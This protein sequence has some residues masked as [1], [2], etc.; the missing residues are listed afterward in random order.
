MK[1]F[2]FVFV[3]LLVIFQILCPFNT[4]PQSWSCGSPFTDTRD[5][6]VY[7]TVLIG[8][9]CW[10][11]QNLNYGTK[12]PSTSQQTNNSI[13]EKY[14][15]NNLDINC[16]TYGG[17]YQWGELVQYI[18]GSSNSASMNKI[19]SNVQG[20]CPDGWLI[21]ADAE[22]CTLATFLENT[23]NCNTLGST[24]STAGGDM[25]EKGY[26]HW[27]SPNTGATN[28]SMF[29]GLP[30]GA[31][32]NNG[33]FSGLT[34]Q[35]GFWAWT[36]YSST[37]GYGW[38]L[39]YNSSS[40]IRSNNNKTIG[41]SVRC[42]KDCPQP[43]APSSGK[44][45]EGSTLIQWWW[46]SSTGAA[47]YKF[48]TTNDFASATDLGTNTSYIE[49]GLTCNTNYTRYIWAYNDC[50][51]SEPTILNETTGV[52][53]QVAPVEGHHV[54]SPTEIIWKWN[55]TSGA[56]SYKWNTTNNF[57]SAVDLGL[58][59]SNTETGLTP[60]T[61]YTR[62]VW[63]TNGNCGTSS[64]TLL[65]Q[66]T[67]TNTFLCGQ[68]INDPRDGGAGQNYSTILL[69]T[70]CWIQQNMNVG[71]I[72]DETGQTND[73][74]IEKL[75]S[76]N[77]SSNCTIYGGLYTWDEMMQYST[78]PGTQGICPTGWSLPTDD[79]WCALTTY[80]DNNYHCGDPGSSVANLIK[81]KGTSHWSSPNAGA[82]NASN[83][84]ALPGGGLIYPSL[85]YD[86]IGDIADLWT[87]TQSNDNDANSRQIFYDQSYVSNSSLDKTSFLSV[88][89]MKDC[90]PPQAP[91]EGIHV[92]TDR[93]IIWNWSTV[94]DA[95][96]YRWNSTNDYNSATELLTN[97]YTEEGLLPNTTYTRY[98][99]AFKDGS[100][101]QITPLHA[102]TSP[103]FQCPSHVADQDGNIYDVVQICS[104]CWTK[105]NMNVGTYIST[106]FG[107]QTDNS[108]IEKYCLQDNSANCSEWGGYYQ[109]AE[110]LQY[111]GATNNNIWSPPSGPIKGICPQG[112]HIPSSDEWS[113][114]INNY[115]GELIAGNHL[116]E[117][118]Q[119]H[120]LSP[121]A[122]DNLSGF[123]YLGN[124]IF[125]P[126]PISVWTNLG[127]IGFAWTTNELTWQP[128]HAYSATTNFPLNTFTT[129]LDQTGKRAAIGVRC[130]MDQG[131]ICQLIVDAGTSSTICLGQTTRLG[132]DPTINGGL[133][134]Y[135]FTW[136]TIP[137][138]SWS[139]NTDLNPVVAP[140]QTTTY[141]L[142]VTDF[143]G[144][145]NTQTSAVTIT[146]LPSCPCIYPIT[147]DKNLLEPYLSTNSQGIVALTGEYDGN[148]ITYGNSS[149][150]NITLTDPNDINY[151]RIFIAKFT[152]KGYPQWVH[153]I[154]C[155]DYYF[156]YTNYKQL[157]VD[158]ANNTFLIVY[159]PYTFYLEDGTPYGNNNS[160]P[161]IN[162]IKFNP[163]GIIEWIKTF[164][165]N[166]NNIPGHPEL[167]QSDDAIYLKAWASSNTSYY[168]YTVNTGDFIAKI[169]KSGGSIPWI[170][171][172][173]LWTRWD[174]N[175][176]Y[177]NNKLYLHHL[178][179]ITMLDPNGIDSQE[180]TINQLYSPDVLRGFDYGGGGSDMFYVSSYHSICTG[181]NSYYINGLQISQNGNQYVFNPTNC[182]IVSKTWPSFAPVNSNV[183]VF[184]EGMPLGVYYNSIGKYQ[185]E[186]GSNVYWSNQYTT[187]DY[188]SLAANHNQSY[189]YY[190]HFTLPFFT[191]GTSELGQFNQNNP[192]GGDFGCYGAKDFHTGLYPPES[193]QI[194]A[195]DILIYPD[196]TTGTFNCHKGNKVDKIEYLQIFDS[197]GKPVYRMDNVPVSNDFEVSLPNVSNGMYFIRFQTKTNSISKKIN[198]IR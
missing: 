178:N 11:Q 194:S 114:L 87:S 125:T 4:F 116:K 89:C 74:I 96:G 35:G 54:A 115:G 121:S 53:Y 86:H 153:S 104:Q 21:P 152:D 23:I 38:G 133:P 60:N 134:S 9:Q 24:G 93:Q 59:V 160:T 190:L 154:S 139:N 14:C 185:M 15:Y 138:S 73:N 81:E 67:Q 150:G 186:N 155:N 83:F 77:I 131:P 181:D 76:H 156:D 43:D 137:P 184:Y 28:G 147:F 52:S 176:T 187:N 94:T 2:Y 193:A 144:T 100:Y 30:G 88:R 22:W 192:G 111:N 182:F 71:T 162:V 107:D 141:S 161:S 99:W 95:I 72:A 37:S 50:N 112:W 33:T 70:Q 85:N 90:T 32:F 197:F 179:A 136:S 34:T 108:L 56:T 151:K 26:N 126:D 140:T 19:P 168:S 75:C 143:G 110:A 148:K 48:N 13:A 80:L 65:T 49:T 109:W 91:T 170:Y 117:Q 119:V 174:D 46:N 123:T 55:P 92:P 120:W 175:L 132:G 164:V 172:N 31:R 82:N 39:G 66:R 188:F 118:G 36:E 171:Q 122:G 6:T 180:C 145:G 79:D 64:P 47:G 97:S 98:V 58:I 84:T 196:P 27:L 61:V 198:L 10:F 124:G 29:T 146:V 57:S 165:D 195:S 113:F 17:L 62:Y 16:G 159:T 105:K 45:I 42:F 158:E 191:P 8:N 106:T 7:N 41:L 51:H 167:V 177:A 166:I 127:I 103:G 12:I 183:F 101:S 69:G 3:F 68:T 78:T 149:I 5:N 20:L 1:K 102:I 40:I 44:D 25:K 135:V 63:A 18:N 169:M 173:S 189:G 128:D 142:T 130:V 157:L 129:S 163:L